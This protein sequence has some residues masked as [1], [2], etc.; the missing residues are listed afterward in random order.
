[1]FALLLA[2]AV[3]DQGTEQAQV[4]QGTTGAR[5][6]RLEL[7]AGGLVAREGEVGAAF[8]TYRVGKGKPQ[9]AYLVLFKHRLGPETPLERSEET[10]A[11]GDAAS[12][13]QALVLDGVRLVIEYQLHLDA[14]G[15]P[16][17]TITLNRKAI[18]P[19]KGRVL[20]VDLTVN[21]PRWEQRRGNLPLDVGETMSKKSAEELVR[22]LLSTL[23]AKDSKVKEFV[24]AASR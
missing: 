11:D 3:T 9:L 22:K 5:S 18:E 21:P 12:S 24:D 1:M 13:K 15:P 20:L 17:R 8:G 19:T 6:D 10:S 16:R 4:I 23:A 14:K 2:L 7:H